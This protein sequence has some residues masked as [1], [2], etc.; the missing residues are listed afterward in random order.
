MLTILYVALALFLGFGGGWLL[1]GRATERQHE[2]EI[3]TP[4]TPTGTVTLAAG[5][6]LEIVGNDHVLPDQS[7]EP[8]VVHSHTETWT[9]GP[10]PFR[11]V[12]LDGEVQYEGT[13]GGLA[14]RTIE[15]LRCARAEWRAYRHGEIWDWGPR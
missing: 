14:R 12:T 7:P 15:G 6:E 4:P 9:S 11:V 10:A 1:W 8:A 2:H 5:E 3:G 13:K